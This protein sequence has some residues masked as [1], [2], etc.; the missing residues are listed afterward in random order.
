MG[1]G[2]RREE[3]LYLRRQHFSK[4]DGQNYNDADRGVRNAYVRQHAFQFQKRRAQ[5]DIAGERIVAPKRLTSFGVPQTISALCDLIVNLLDLERHS[6]ILRTLQVAFEEEV[7]F[8]LQFVAFTLTFDQRLLHGGQ[9]CFHYEAF[10]AQFSRFLNEF[11]LRF[12][13]TT[14]LPGGTSDALGGGRLAIA[15]NGG[16]FMQTGDSTGAAILVQTIFL[17]DG[18][19]QGLLGQQASK[20][21][22]EAV[23]FLKPY[24]V[25]ALEM[26]RKA[27]E[28]E[29]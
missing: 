19:L 3:R 21:P 6:A 1:S 10:A 15:P 9:P 18:H 24:Y 25:A 13:R 7:P 5:A 2:A 4:L 29:S 11:S 8:G 28:K 23:E 14:V 17:K 22:E 12:W 16:S 27:M 26:M 20:S